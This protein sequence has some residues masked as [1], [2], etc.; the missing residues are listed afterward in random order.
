MCSTMT[1]RDLPAAL[2]ASY[3]SSRSDTPFLTYFSSTTPDSDS[4]RTRLKA[5]LFLQGS[6]LY[7]LSA[8][9]ARLS[10]HAKIL[11]LELA[12]LEGKLGNHRAAL[13]ALVHELNDGTS[14]EAYCTLGGEVVPAKT[15]Q[16]IGERTGLQQWA[17]FV[18]PLAAPGKPQ[19]TAGAGAMRRQR[20]VDEEVKKGLVMILLEV[21]MSGGC[22]S[23]S[24]ALLTTITNRDFLCVARRRRTAPRSY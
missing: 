21:Y 3:S 10:G 18:T 2:A 17:A 23:S 4:K 19:P 8:V 9:H 6:T 12:I 16:Q 15:A 11:K 14:A 7:D 22:V 1:P 24:L 13:A 20:T 5:I